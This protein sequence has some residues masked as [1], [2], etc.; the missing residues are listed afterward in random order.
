MT[1]AMRVLGKAD[2]FLPLPTLRV[3]LMS[4]PRHRT[5]MIAALEAFLVR[6]MRARMGAPVSRPTP[7]NKRLRKR[8]KRAAGR[9]I[10]N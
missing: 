5:E 9:Y 8:S 3:C 7:P 4:S 1:A 2:G 6:R 10:A